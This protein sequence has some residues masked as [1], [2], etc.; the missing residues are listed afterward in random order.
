MFRLGRTWGSQRRNPPTAYLGVLPSLPMWS[1]GLQPR[2]PSQVFL[3]A[4]SGPRAVALYGVSRA[5]GCWAVRGL[6]FWD[7]Y[8]RCQLAAQYSTVPMPWYDGF[9]T[10]PKTLFWRRS[11]CCQLSPGFGLRVPLRG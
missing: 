10:V 6:L 8:I 5:E 4:L 1:R 11:I 2:C 7:N 9:A 3:V